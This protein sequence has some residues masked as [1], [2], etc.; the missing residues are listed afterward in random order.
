MDMLVSLF[1][2]FVE[3]IKY[4]IG[5]KFFFHGKVD[6]IWI[7]VAGLL[8]VLVQSVTGR[9]EGQDIIMVPTLC[10]TIAGAI[11]MDGKIGTKIARF[12]WLFMVI[13]S[14]DSMVAIL[15]SNFFRDDD[16]ITIVSVT[17]TIILLIVGG[18]L[19]R[20]FKRKNN[21]KYLLTMVYGI[22]FLAA[23]AV[24]I[25][26]FALYII[27]REIPH[28]FRVIDLDWITMGALFFLTLL[29]VMILHLQRV[30]Q[31]LEESIEREKNLKKI[32][33]TYY[34]SLLEKEEETKRY[35][36][37]MYNHFL[38]IRGLAKEEKALNTLKYVES[39]ENKWKSEGSQVYETGNFILN[40]LLHEHLSEIKDAEILI[41]GFCKRDM[42]IDE[43]DFCTIFS[44]LIQNAVEELGRLEQEKKYFIMEIR[45]GKEHTMI[46]ILNSSCR[47]ADQKK[48]RLPTV[49]EDKKNHGIGMENV[50]STVKKYQGELLWGGNGKEFKVSVSMK[51]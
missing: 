24:C 20:F 29:P 47:I 27:Y 16:K 39:L 19:F 37:D 49:K 8:I 17:T 45:Q 9:L 6:R 35:R 10:A 4:W 46:E 51:I 3:L 15:Y 28:S 25:V 7:S 40:L 42:L 2:Y 11:M 34:R 5:N 18:Y 30:Q 26:I 33:E 13:T 1:V 44:N 43:A 14:L 21:G 48:G 12:F 31:L 38:A 23:F 36:H 50:K 41:K 32:Q 22:L